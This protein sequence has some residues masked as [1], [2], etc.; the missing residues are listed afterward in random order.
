MIRLLSFIFVLLLSVSS[1][2]AQQLVKGKVVD[3]Q[4]NAIESVNVIAMRQAD[5]TYLAGRVTNASGEFQ[6]E[7]LPAESYLVFSSIGYQKQTHPAASQMHVVMEENQGML[8]EVSV[9]A[10]RLKERAGGYAVQLQNNPLMKGKNLSQAIDLL[11]N[12]AVENGSIEILG[13]GVKAIYVDGQSISTKELLAIPLE[14]VDRVEVDYSSV[15]R[16]GAGKPGGVLRIF[17]KKQRESGWT[18]QVS[19]QTKVL[20]KQGW[21]GGGTWNYFTAYWKKLTIRNSTGL[22]RN[23]YFSDEDVTSLDKATGVELQ[24]SRKYR[25]WTNDF[26]NRTSISYAIA[27]KHLLA[28]SFLYWYDKSSLENTTRDMLGVENYDRQENPMHSWQWVTT[29]RWNMNSATVMELSSDLLRRKAEQYTVEQRPQFYDNRVGEHTTMWRVKPELRHDFKGGTSLTVGGDFQLLQQDED[30]QGF[31]ATTMK[32]MTP[33]LYSSL[34]GSVGSFQYEAGFRALH[35]S[36]R[37]TQDGTE[38]KH[39]YTGIFPVLSAMY[40]LSAK[41]AHLLNLQVERSME[42]IPYSAVSGYKKYSGA[43][44]YEVGNP[45]LKTPVQTNVTALLSLWQKLNLMF[46]VGHLQSPIYFDRRTDA[47]DPRVSYLTPMNG[48][49][50]LLNVASVEWRQNLTKW[51]HVKTSAFLRLHSA[52]AGV[53]VRNQSSTFFRHN[54]T[55]TF[56]PTFGAGLRLSYEPSYEILDRKLESVFSVGGYVNKSFLK[57]KMNVRLEFLAY[58]MER[59]L[60]TD[61][62]WLRHRVDKHNQYPWFSLSVSYRF[63]GGKKVKTLSDTQSLQNYQKTE[64]ANK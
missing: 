8:S 7:S 17:L 58:G 60:V 62:S 54:S 36:M 39:N 53:V 22:S 13:R 64:D 34:S 23:L 57:E 21:L 20:P 15:V 41:H 10:R 26:F 51:W 50:Q 27:P 43:F 11:P 37:T 63:S 55:F 6:F 31:A 2:L 47:A 18:D 52:D 38:Y 29:Y 33:A 16:E 4:G 1:S 35:Q 28:T 19:A 45:D 49:Y 56:S 25:D 14:Q 40:L 46:M 61:N 32:T 12:L 48:S 3:V 59:D 30:A 24:H 44:E 42:T 9:I 5:S